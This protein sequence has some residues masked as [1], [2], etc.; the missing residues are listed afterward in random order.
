[1]G[2][3][4]REEAFIGETSYRRDKCVG[5]PYAVGTIGMGL[6]QPFD[7]LPQSAAKTDGDDQIV[8]AAIACR[9]D[10]VARGGRRDH[11]KAQKRHPVLQKIHQAYGEVATQNKNFAGPV[12]SFCQPRH[13]LEI[14]RIAQR[15]EIP[16]V[17]LQ[18]HLSMRE[19]TGTRLFAV[20]HAFQRCRAR[21][22]Q[23]VQVR[24]ESS[25]AVKAEPTNDPQHR[26]RICPKL[27][28]DI[29]NAQQHIIAGMLL[30]RPYQFAA[31]FAQALDS[32]RK[33]WDMICATIFHM[34]AVH[35][36][37]LSV[38]ATPRPPASVDTCTR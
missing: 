38:S 36:S 6:L 8:A 17:L 28:G 30:N 5:D 19:N 9:V 14:Q 26:C 22:R 24:L 34:R 3:H 27:G 37:T 16:Y 12:D 25:I 35:G 33:A 1:M 11:G 2:F 15:L 21:D 7:G 10:A 31:F 13:A 20:A 18:R 23:F 4:R 32:F 29:A